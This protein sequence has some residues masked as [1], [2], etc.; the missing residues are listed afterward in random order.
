MLVSAEARPRVCAIVLSE[1]ETVTESTSPPPPAGQLTLHGDH[2]SWLHLALDGVLPRAYRLPG[3]TSLWP[4]PALFV[5]DGTA[6]VGATLDLLDPEGVTLARLLVSDEHVDGTGR[7]LAGEIT[8]VSGFSLVDHLSL[9][10]TPD[11]LRASLPDDPVWALW[12]D[13][14]VPFAVRE[15]VAA[16]ARAAGALVLEVAALPTGRETSRVANLPVRLALA[17]QTR[18]QSDRLVALPWPNVA[19]EAEGLRL[20]AHVAAA[21]GAT[22][23]VVAVPVPDDLSARIPVRTSTVAPEQRTV[24]TALLDSWVLDATPL[25]AWAAEPTVADELRRLHRPATLSGLTVM[26]SGLS[27]SGKSTVARALAVRL[28]EHEERSVTLLDG[29]VVR[30]H[31]SK[32]LGFSRPDRITNVLRIGFVASEITK[33]GGVA[34]CCPIAPYDETRRQVRAMVEEHGR[35]VLVHVATPLAECERRDR[36]GLYA[37]AR[38]GEIPEFTGIS[39][40]YEEPTDAE[41][42]IDTTGRTVEECVDEVHAALVRLGAVR[43]R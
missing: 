15:Q 5:P 30:H 4:A 42:V 28:M 2:L 21:F 41:V 10:A 7:W 22:E 24:P 6:Q 31:L 35:F 9:R 36:K 29:D 40:P 34:V 32:G 38:R 27:G 18:G 16:E 12:V 19:W 23:L 3:D 8:P 25:P 13:A 14:P 1:E 37:K 39:D 33:A 43:W 11:E 20:R 26:L 17:E